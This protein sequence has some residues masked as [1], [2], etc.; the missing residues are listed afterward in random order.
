M[1]KSRERSDDYR[2]EEFFE[3]DRVY[4]CTSCVATLLRRV[5]LRRN[6]GAQRAPV[7][8]SQSALLEN[9]RRLYSEIT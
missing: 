6:L 1:K 4:V 3:Y 2:A 7:F 9:A 5:A 8:R